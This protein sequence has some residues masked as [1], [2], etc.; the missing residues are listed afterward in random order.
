MARLRDDDGNVIDAIIQS[1][2]DEAIAGAGLSEEDAQALID[3]TVDPL[4]AGVFA[5]VVDGG[6]SAITTGVKADLVVPFACTLTSWTLLADQSGS[7]VIDIWKDSYA[8][9]PPVVGDSISTSKPTLSAAAKAQDLTI[10]DWSEVLAAGDILR[11]N[12]DSAATVQR[13][14]LSLAYTRA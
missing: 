2:M 4:K 11:I 9:F 6:G 5:I 12:V 10:T 1:E 7:I 13:V 8:N 3:D 14:T